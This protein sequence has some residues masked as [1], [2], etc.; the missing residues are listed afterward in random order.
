MI[1]RLTS[2]IKGVTTLCRQGM[3]FIKKENI[4]MEKDI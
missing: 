4:R 2:R 3:S 1:N